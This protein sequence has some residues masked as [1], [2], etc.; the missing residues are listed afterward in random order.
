MTKTY[1]ISDLHLSPERDDITRCFEQ[2]MAEQ[3]PTAD[4]LY[5]LGDLFEV[6]IGDD[7][8]SEFVQRISD[9]FNLLSTRVPIFFIRGNRDFLLGRRFCRKAGITL[10]PEQKVIDL[11]GTPTLLMHGDELCTQDVNYQ[12]FRRIVG[13]PSCALS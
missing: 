12:R 13:T 10:L 8:R 2:F 5:V 9:C 4:A 11:Y 1:F 3:A 6:W 7:D